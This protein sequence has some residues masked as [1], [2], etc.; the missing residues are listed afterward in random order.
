MLHVDWVRSKKC[1]KTESKQCWTGDG[2][3]ARTSTWTCTNTSVMTNEG[4]V[5]SNG[6][7]PLGLCLSHQKT[8]MSSGFNTYIEY[9]TTFWEIRLLC[10][11]TLFL[12]CC[13]IE[14][15]SEIP[16]TWGRSSPMLRTITWLVRDVQM[17]D[18]LFRLYYLNSNNKNSNGNSSSNHI[19][20]V[21]YV[22]LQRL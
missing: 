20:T 19:H 16:V 1:S 5:E 13:R 2:G 7:L 14:F 22:K 3:E 12:V 4:L 9:V 21:P 11:L 18:L 17:G 10:N 6:S 8:K 15:G